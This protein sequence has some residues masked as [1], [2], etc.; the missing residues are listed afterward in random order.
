[1]FPFG[2]YPRSLAASGKAI[3]APCPAR[4]TAPAPSTWRT[5]SRRFGTNLPSLGVFENKLHVDTV[6][7]ASPNGAN[8]MAAAPDGTAML[9]SANA[10]TFVISRK[11]LGKISGAYAASSYDQYVVDNIVLNGS[12][13]PV[14]QHGDRA[15]AHLPA[16]SSWTRWAS[17]APRPGASAPGVIQ[18]VDPASGAVIRPTRMV[19]SPLR[20]QPV[21]TGPAAPRQPR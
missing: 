21:S 9:Y 11:D 13:Y 20:L 18:R 7:V 1:M 17:A 19:E 6:L 4:P 12:L 15:A 5:C 8:I 16:S 14:R 3:L 2:H 10:D